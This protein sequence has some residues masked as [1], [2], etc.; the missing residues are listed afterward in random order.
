MKGSGRNI[1]WIQKPTHLGLHFYFYHLVLA[2]AIFDEA[3]DF[4]VELHEDD[5]GGVAREQRDAFPHG[6]EVIQE[7]DDEQDQIQDVEGSFRL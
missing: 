3:L 6:D 4:A 5:V 1:I 2:H 7:E